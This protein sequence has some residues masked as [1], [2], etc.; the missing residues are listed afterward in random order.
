MT[1]ASHSLTVSCVNL[2]YEAEGLPL[3][4]HRWGGPRDW[5]TCLTVAGSWAAATLCGVSGSPAPQEDAGTLREDGGGGGAAC[6]ADRDPPG[7]PAAGRG[8]PVPP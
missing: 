7:A 5:G 6:G 8:S 4:S 3:S 1:N 2:N